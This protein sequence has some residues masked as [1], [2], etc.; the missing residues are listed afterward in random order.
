M[1]SSP[2]V[3]PAERRRLYAANHSRV[4]CENVTSSSSQKPTLENEL[5][6]VTKSLE[7]LDANLQDETRALTDTKTKLETERERLQSNKAADIKRLA[8]LQVR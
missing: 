3:I 8:S 5:V 2:S 6:K 7:K 1:S 4:T